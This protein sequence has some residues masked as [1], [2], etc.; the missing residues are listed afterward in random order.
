MVI[1]LENKPN[2]IDIFSYVLCVLKLDNPTFVWDCWDYGYTPTFAI[3]LFPKKV[4][5][6][7]N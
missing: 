1:L 3:Y 6:E 4:L 7:N 2:T 5:I